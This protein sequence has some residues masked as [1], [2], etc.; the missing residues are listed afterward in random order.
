MGAG[1]DTS[2][3][4]ERT[5]DVMLTTVRTYKMR[6][7]RV[8]ASQQVALDGVAAG[9]DIA[10]LTWTQ[11]LERADGRDIVLDIG[12]G[13]GESVLHYATAEPNRYIVGVEVHRPGVG[14]L[15]R[16]AGALGL[17]N[18][19]VVIGDARQWL[20]D[21]VPNSALVGI[22]LFFPDPWPK[23]RHHKRRF[24]R[25]PVL[26]LLASKC[27][28]QGFLHIAT[29]ISDYAEDAREELSQSRFWQLYGGTNHRRERPVTKFERRAIR[30]NRSVFDLLATRV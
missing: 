22:R 11:L 20:T 8:T 2:A 4:T 3:V 15:C 5:P 24:I 26:D 28:A 1:W 27:A 16:D 12:F 7:G 29:D 13:F 18:I 23:K 14:A 21:V 30:D 6:N 19:A 25:Q 9:F 10:G 17:H